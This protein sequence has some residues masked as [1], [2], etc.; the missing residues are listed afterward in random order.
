LRES[1]GLEDLCSVTF[2][3]TT[4]RAD[5]VLLGSVGST[6][7]RKSTSRQYPCASLIMQWD[8]FR[9][10]KMQ[11]V[12]SGVVQRMDSYN[13][14]DIGFFDKNEPESLFYSLW[15]VVSFSSYGRFFPVFRGRGSQFHT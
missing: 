8:I 1:A 12:A 9:Y 10:Q 15:F 4:D 13:L 6:S 11:K 5:D 7:L 14:H 2:P 3:W